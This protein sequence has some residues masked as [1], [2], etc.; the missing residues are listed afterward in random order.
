MILIESGRTRARED[1]VDEAI[2]DFRE[3]TAVCPELSEAHYQ[4]GNALMNVPGQA[5]AAEATLQRAIDLDPSRADAYYGLGLLRA[6]ARRRG[7]GD[8]GASACDT[9]K[10][11]LV[12]AH[13]ALADVARSRGDWPTAIAELEAVLAWEPADVRARDARTSAI[14]AQAR[15]AQRR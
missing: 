11:S 1:H 5:G 8:G 14:D 15:E 4:L 12:E 3:A 13:R 9:L 6:K 7:A 10:P 2:T